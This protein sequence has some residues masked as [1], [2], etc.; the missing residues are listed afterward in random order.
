[1]SGTW[2]KAEVAERIGE[3]ACVLRRLPVERGPMGHRSNMPEPIREWSDLVGRPDDGLTLGRAP[4]PDGK[5]IARMDEVLGHWMPMLDGELGRLVW[6]W[7]SGYPR[8]AICNRFGIGR[9]TAHRRWL[10]ALALIALRLNDRP[11]RVARLSQ[12]QVLAQAL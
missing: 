3:A 10:Y 12:R 9:S 1:M 2:T 6:M 8:K 4:A 11:E 5:A 7:A